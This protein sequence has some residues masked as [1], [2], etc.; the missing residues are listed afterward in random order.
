MDHNLRILPIHCWERFRVWWVIRA[1]RFLLIDTITH[2]NTPNGFSSP[3][4]PP[5]RPVRPRENSPGS[6]PPL[7]IW[8]RNISSA[9]RK[10]ATRPKSRAGAICNRKTPSAIAKHRIH[11]EAAARA[12]RRRRLNMKESTSVGGLYSL[13]FLLTLLIIG[14]I[15][16]LARHLR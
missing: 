16:I 9:F 10:I 5:T 12:D 7:G 2:I 4:V 8:P 11:D 6:A 13:R 15:P 1:C 3:P 14:H